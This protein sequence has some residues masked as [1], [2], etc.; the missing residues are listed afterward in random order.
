MIRQYVNEAD[1]ER[2]TAAN[3]QRKKKKKKVETSEADI[4]VKTIYK[5][6][7]VKVNP[8]DNERSDGS[9]PNG[10]PL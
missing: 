1:T 2:K 6:K 10:N 4:S 9:I 8:V 5:R 7:G 3:K